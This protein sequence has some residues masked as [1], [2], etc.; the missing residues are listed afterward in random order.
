MLADTE[1]APIAAERIFVSFALTVTPKRNRGVALTTNS[2]ASMSKTVDTL[3]PYEPITFVEERVGEKCP[4]CNETR[5]TDQIHKGRLTF[6]CGA[7]GSMGL[8]IEITR[9]EGDRFLPFVQQKSV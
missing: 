3:F 9:C 5:V 8:G 4:F 6:L 7:S 1:I 2:G